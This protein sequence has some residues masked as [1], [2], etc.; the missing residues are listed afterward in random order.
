[1]DKHQIWIKLVKVEDV[2]QWKMEFIIIIIQFLYN[3]YPLYLIKYV[4]SLLVVLEAIHGVIVNV[5]FQHMDLVIMM[6]III[7][8]ILPIH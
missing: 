4:N 1:M 6:Q 2:H 5:I 7:F 3:Y 8:Y